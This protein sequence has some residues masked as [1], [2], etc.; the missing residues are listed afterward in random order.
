MKYFVHPAILVVATTLLLPSAAAAAER[1]R[2]AESA[3]LH[4]WLT[5]AATAHTCGPTRGGASLLA[6]TARFYARIGYRT[7]WMHRDGLSRRG[8][9]LLQILK[10][11]AAN[12]LAGEDYVLPAPKGFHDVTLA[13]ADGNQGAGLPPHM[14]MDLLLTGTLLRYAN[15][16]SRGRISARDLNR[17]FGQPENEGNLAT[18]L[19]AAVDADNLSGYLDAIAPP[20]PAYDRLKTALQRYERVRIRGGWAKLP[21][22]PSLRRGDHDARIP[23]LRRRLVLTG[24]LE[25]SRPGP[26]KQYDGTIEGAVMRFQHRHGLVPDGVVG[27]RTLKALNVS[28]DDR[29]RMLQ[30]NM[31][32]WRWYPDSFGERYVWVNIPDYTLTVMEQDW[33]VRRMRA[34][35]GR[36]KR[37]TPN[38]SGLMTYLQFNPYWNVPGTIAR[39]DILPKIMSDPAYLIRQGFKVFDSWEQDATALNPEGIDWDQ[40]S[41]KH[42]P[43][44]LRQEPSALNALGQVKFMFPNQQSVYIH[45]TPG[46]TLFQRNRRTFSSGCVRVEAPLVLAT[47][48]LRNHRWNPARIKD[49]LGSGKQKTVVLKNPIPVHLVYFTAWIDESGRVNFR[50]DVYGRDRELRQAIAQRSRPTLICSRQPAAGNLLASHTPDHR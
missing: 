48:L 9:S 37:Q 13:L 50:E 29:I 10:N 16:I 23:L 14:Q 6:P 2:S 27:K 1:P 11:A 42:F 18:E 38:L 30:L 33:A 8:E 12:G 17:G 43:Y 15:H 44:R 25:L 26:D 28:V 41:K 40:V 36:T 24:D 21:P 49:T 46:K 32:R 5:A 22:G 20:H 3:S 7:V 39:K 4:A 31:E 35:V 34:I 19:A 45:D 47:Y